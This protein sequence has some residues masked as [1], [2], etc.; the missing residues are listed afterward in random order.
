MQLRVYRDDAVGVEQAFVTAGQF[1]EA[2][3]GSLFYPGAFV[4]QGVGVEFACHLQ[5]LP[6]TLSGLHVPA[7]FGLHAGRCPQAQFL[8]VGSGIVAPGDESRAGAADAH[9]GLRRIRFSPDACGIGCRSDD[10]EFVVHHAAT[11]YAVTVGD[12]L[13]FGL[14]RVNQDHVHVTVRSHA[15]SL[16]SP[17]RDDVYLDTRLPG[18][19]REYLFQKARGDGAGG[20]G[21]AKGI[22][23][24][25]QDPEQE[26]A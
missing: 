11:V 9:K 12:E 22:G 25:R 10:E 2:G 6:H 5:Y 24:H 3:S 4:H 26:S 15:Q 1:L 14:R 18:E 21:E 20:G 13:L 16:A 17:H 19:Y 7:A 8:L 23:E